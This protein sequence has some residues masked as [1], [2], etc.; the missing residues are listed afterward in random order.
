M[1]GPV[2]TLEECIIQSL[3]SED[4]D[5]TILSFQN[6]YIPSV[7]KSLYLHLRNDLLKNRFERFINLWNVITSPSAK[8]DLRKIWKDLDLWT[9]CW[10]RLGHKI[11]Y[12]ELNNLVYN[13]VIR[14]GLREY[15]LESNLWKHFPIYQPIVIQG[16]K[17]LLYP[18]PIVAG[19]A[20][21]PPGIVISGRYSDSIEFSIG[22]TTVVYISDWPF[23][24]E[25]QFNQGQKAGRNYRHPDVGVMS[26]Y[27]ELKYPD[28]ISIW[29]ALISKKPID[30]GSENG[31]L[32]LKTEDI[33]LMEPVRGFPNVEFQKP[34]VLLSDDYPI[35]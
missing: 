24:F 28:N 26:T 29:N 25:G 20:I 21:Q 12:P 34:V 16:L 8:E 33:Y 2:K 6:Y 14:S 17:D 15:S 5:I 35:F 27:F 9:P 7:Q 1:S 30:L 10:L 31:Y 32:I 3:S 23:E 11:Q 13:R 4:V 19:I 22:T 18:I